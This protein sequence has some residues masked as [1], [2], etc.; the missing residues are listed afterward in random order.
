MGHI[1]FYTYCP[2]EGVAKIRF[3]G[4]PPLGA[5]PEDKRFLIPFACKGT[6][7]VDP[8]LPY[9]LRRIYSYMPFYTLLIPKGAVTVNMSV[10]AWV[11]SWWWG[12]W[13]EYTQGVIHFT[14]Y[15]FPS[16]IAPVVQED[17]QS[18]P[19]LRFAPTT[20]TS[21]FIELYDP[22]SQFF[23]LH[24][25]LVIYK[26]YQSRFLYF[27]YWLQGP[28]WNTNL[29]NS[30]REVMSYWERMRETLLL[31]HDTV[32]NSEEVAIY[33]H[34]LG[35]ISEWWRGQYRVLK[36]I[37]SEQSKELQIGQNDNSREPPN[38]YLRLA[39]QD[40]TRDAIAVVIR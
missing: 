22:R 40:R 25:Y 29:F 23:G 8:P 38:Y 30:I 24:V 20:D 32:I 17:W 26:A 13:R 11:A 18:I 28:R 21:P 39:V 6:R 31:F 19:N 15:Q 33:P 27:E 34:P 7:R 9:K 4:I 14:T 36:V 37:N 1:E 10:Y 5:T 3:A 2:G 16:W 12:A 35:R